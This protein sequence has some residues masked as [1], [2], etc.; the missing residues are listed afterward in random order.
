MACDVCTT[1]TQGKHPSA[2]HCLMMENVAEMTAWLPTTEANV[3]AI[4][5]KKQPCL[6]DVDKTYEEGK[7]NMEAGI[8]EVGQPKAAQ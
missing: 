4:E 8:M 1:F 3:A 6:K 5:K 2:W 7:I